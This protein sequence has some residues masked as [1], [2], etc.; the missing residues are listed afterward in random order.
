MVIFVQVIVVVEVVGLLLVADRVIKAMNIAVWVIIIVFLIVEV[1][2]FMMVVV[3]GLMM[4]LMVSMVL[5]VQEVVVFVV[6]II[7]LLL[8]RHRI[9]ILIVAV[10]FPVTDWLTLWL[11][12][13]WVVSNKARLLLLRC[14]LDWRPCCGVSSKHRQLSERLW[15]PCSLVSSKHRALDK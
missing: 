12:T 9:L 3:M 14:K 2:G 10:V 4:G 6:E 5:S 13:L 15:S 8:M 11:P 1:V 7:I